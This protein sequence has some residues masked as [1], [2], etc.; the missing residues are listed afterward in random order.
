MILKW[1]DPSQKMRQIFGVIANVI[2]EQQINSVLYH[3]R[4]HQRHTRIIFSPVGMLPCGDEQHKIFSDV[5]TA[6]YATT[7]KLR[8]RSSEVSTREISQK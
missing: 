1:A 4:S 6:P 2:Y 7:R 5:E 8:R 3:I